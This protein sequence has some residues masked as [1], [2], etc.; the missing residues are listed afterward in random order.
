M[1]IMN[2][3][4][5]IVGSGAGGSA[6]AYG[7]AECGLRTLLIERGPVLP[8]DGSTLDVGRVI[9]QG[10]FKDKELWLDRKGR[11]FQPSEYANLGGKTKWY[12]A[13]LLRQ[14]PHEFAADETHQCPAWPI[15]YD[16]IAPF[17][18]RAETL[19][20]PK[21]FATEPNLEKIVAGLQR[22]DQSWQREALPVGLSEE[23]LKSPHDAHHFDGFANPHGLKSDAEFSLLRRVADRPNLTVLTG[24]PVEALVGN[25]GAPE[26]IAGVHCANGKTYRARRVVLSAGALHSPRLLQAYMEET[27]LDTQLPAYANI[28][29]NYKCHLNS[30]LIAF[31]PSVV[32]DALRKTTILFHCGFPHSSVQN[33]GWL[34][35]ELIAPELPSFAPHVV[36]NIVGR[37]A[38]GFWITTEDGSHPDNRVRRANGHCLAEI[39]YDLDRLTPAIREHKKLIHTLQAQLLRTLHVGFVKRMP[40]DNTAHACGTLIAGLDPERSVVDRDGKVHGMAN[41]HVADG[42]VMSRSGRVNPAFTIYAWGLRLADC[43]R[44]ELMEPGHA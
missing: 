36:S 16:E 15:S 38:Y 24:L 32:T 11:K 31:S 22:C 30:A 7:L 13:A 41:L 42:S 23:I 40:V 33:L 21:R 12:G 4:V 1:K 8:G 5:I 27:G 2:Y 37:R 20:K 17:Y 19:L 26:K 10:L 18:D 34:D 43:L 14:A 9:R 6:T 25:A 28:G 3:D 35:G 29:R 44:A 39:D